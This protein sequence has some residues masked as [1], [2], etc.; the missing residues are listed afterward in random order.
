MA[1]VGLKDQEIVAIV[2][3]GECAY[4]A[5]ENTASH[6]WIWIYAFIRALYTYTCTSYAHM[7]MLD[8]DCGP[9]VD[10]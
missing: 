8:A 4:A 2:L 7:C 10:L 6:V 5:V 1:G 9:I 3:Q